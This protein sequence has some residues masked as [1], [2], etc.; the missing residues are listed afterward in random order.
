MDHDVL[1]YLDD[2]HG[3]KECQSWSR[4][5]DKTANR[6]FICKGKDTNAVI[7]HIEILF[8]YLVC[9]QMVVLAILSSDFSIWIQIF[10][11]H[12]YQQ[13]LFII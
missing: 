1:S 8:I 4:N 10:K 9:C 5:G 13:V 3:R 7:L 6:L 12:S 11:I 2:D